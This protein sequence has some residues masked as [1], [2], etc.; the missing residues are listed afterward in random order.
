MKIK[1]LVY[2]NAILP[3]AVS[4]NKEQRRLKV[5]ENRMLRKIF[6]HEEDEIRRV[7]GECIKRRFTT[8]TSRQIMIRATK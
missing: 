5:F 4:P 7:W 8:N 6:E 2:R 3:S 1:I